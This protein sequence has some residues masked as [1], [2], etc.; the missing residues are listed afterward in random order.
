MIGTSSLTW[1]LLGNPDNDIVDLTGV[2]IFSHE[3]TSGNIEVKVRADVIPELDETYQV[4][5]TS[6]EPVSDI[7]INGIKYAHWLLSN[8]I[9][10]HGEVYSI[11][12]YVIKFV[13]AL[14]QVCGFLQVL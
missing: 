5:L 13:S 14:R 1:K 7:Q 6:V 3:Q 2:L 11:Q 4:Q 12:Y 10:V 9:L 8:D